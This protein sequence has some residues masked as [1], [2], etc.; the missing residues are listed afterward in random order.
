M[1]DD[2]SHAAPAPA[3]LAD[4]EPAA[5]LSEPARRFASCRWHK[6]ADGGQPAYCTHRE[7]LPM[8][9]MNGFSP[10]SWCPDCTFYNLRRVP[11]KNGF[12]PGKPL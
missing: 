3:P 1:Y 7:V 4:G 11:R 10:D 5:P 12:E 9:G 8:A 2:T 6:P